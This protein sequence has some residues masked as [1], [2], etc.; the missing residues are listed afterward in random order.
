MNKLRALI[1]TVVIAL[2]APGWATAEPFTL[3]QTLRQVMWSYPSVEIA[4]LQARRAQQ[5]VIKARSM[6]GWGLSGQVGAS[7][8]LSPFSGTP[9]DRIDANSGLERALSSGGTFG[10]SASYTREDSTF[11]FSG[12]P[13]PAHTTRVDASYRMPLAKGAG[14][15]Q[16]DEGLRSA[17]AG[18]RIARANAQSVRDGL[19][20]QTMELFFIAAL[21]KARLETSKDAIDR[22]LRLKRYIRGNA[23]LGLSEEK[24]LLQAE[25]QLQARIAEYDALVAA[26]EQQR[27]SINRLLNRPRTA[28]FTP[29]LH[30]KDGS[31]KGGIDAILE[32]AKVHS[33][34]LHRQLAQIEI[35]E[36]LLATSKDA[37]RSTWDL[38]F[39]VGYGNKQGS[40]GTSYTSTSD[41]AAGVRLEYRK[42]L[43]RSGLNAEVTQAQ[44]DRSI[45]LR[46]AERIRNDLIYSVNGLIAG[47]E[48]TN[49]SLASQRQRVIVERKKIDEASKRYRSGR[50]VT[51][52][53]IQFENDYQLSKLAREQQR[54]E[55]AR[56]HASLDLVRGILLRDAMAPAAG[57]KGEQ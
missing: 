49:K 45:A 13:N 47:I 30:D 7:H 46:E 43:D 17:N 2:A 11:V 53:L 29:V 32:Q 12:F 19:A 18:E 55:L 35:A 41:Y 57:S 34:D 8:D 4:R 50:T 48:K 21:T 33:P 52:Q 39:G 26:W 38:V 40:V 10:I 27:T 54:I 51:T 44:I 15:P 31:V 24:D 42:A 25:A 1:S 36:S 14:N 28:E 6:L 23:R 56:K 37:S 16:Y 3:H 20:T 9:S 5:D 22:A